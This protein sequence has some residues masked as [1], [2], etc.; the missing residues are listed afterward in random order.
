M[1]TPA[2]TPIP[3]GW[4]TNKRRG[5]Q[6]SRNTKR[7]R[8]SASEDYTFKTVQHE[9][10]SRIAGASDAFECRIAVQL[11]DLVS[12]H[13]F[14]QSLEHPAST[15]AESIIEITKAYEEQYMRECLPGETPC[16][17]GDECECRVID[18]SQPFV[19]TCFVIPQVRHA[20]NN[21]CVLCLRKTTQIMFYRVVTQGLR[22]NAP[23]QR[24]GNICGRDNEYH[25]SVMLICPPSG[26][27][28][29]MP[30][31]IVSHQRNRYRVVEHHGVKYI[32]QHGV[33][34]QDFHEPP[35]PI[36]V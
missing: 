5:S 19:G 9:I 32:E 8:K 25:P 21:M 30:L 29:C 35:P 23:I 11:N 12:R 7:A 14:T 4:E 15:A 24:H 31:P 26:P 6:V 10:S 27:V 20:D 22:T 17:M 33:G 28:H 16:V 18:R 34:M 36:S 13:T 1:S 2:S 3:P